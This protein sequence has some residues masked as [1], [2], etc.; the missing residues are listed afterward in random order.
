[1]E[2]YFSNDIYGCLSS[3]R[4]QCF[5][6]KKQNQYGCYTMESN[7]SYYSG[8]CCLTFA[9][10]HVRHHVQNSNGGEQPDDDGSN[11]PHFWSTSLSLV[12]A[13]IYPYSNKF[14]H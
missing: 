11:P 1:M 6:K 7:C 4:S 3:S 14:G 8:T 13:I 12:F 9:A 10:E 2:D 5:K